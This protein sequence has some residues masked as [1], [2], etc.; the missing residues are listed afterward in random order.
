MKN[1]LNCKVIRLNTEDINAQIQYVA[2]SDGVYKY[3]YNDLDWDNAIDA[4]GFKQHLYLVSNREIKEGDWILF[5]NKSVH[6]CTIVNEL[7]V[8]VYEKDKY[9]GSFNLQ[10]CKKIEATTNPLLGVP[11]NIPFRK[12]ARG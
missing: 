9:A 2:E 10:T 1:Q 3:P 12:K 7:E 6:K 4:Q 11:E 5:D 8:I